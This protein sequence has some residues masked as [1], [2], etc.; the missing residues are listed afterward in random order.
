MKT[1]YRYTLFADYFQFCLQDEDAD[2]DLS[3][4]WTDETVSRS[5]WERLSLLVAQTISPK[6][7]EFKS[8]LV[9]IAPEYI[10]AT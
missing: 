8:S 6:R 5:S 4:E 2:G 1:S 9:I 10:T 3:E 7:R